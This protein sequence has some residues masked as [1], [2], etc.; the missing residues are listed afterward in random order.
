MPGLNVRLDAK[1][2]GGVTK[3]NHMVAG[4]NEIFV[5]SKHHSKIR[6]VRDI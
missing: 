6:D 4:L 5:Y 1:L 3:L 2:Q